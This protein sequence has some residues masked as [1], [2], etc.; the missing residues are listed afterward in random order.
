MKSYLIY[1]I[2]HGMID[3][4]NAGQYI[5]HTDVPL[6]EAGEAQLRQMAEDYEYPQPEIVFS[7]PLR[8]C[9]RT[10]QIL[11]PDAD[12]IP[13]RELIECNF[14]EFEGKTAEELEKHPVFP[15]WLAGEEG[16][17]PPFGE[18]SRDFQQRVMQGFVRIVEGLLK[19]GTTRAA[20]VTHGGVITTLL[21]TFGLPQAPMHEWMMPEGC[22]YTVRVTPFLWTSG[23]KMEVFEELPIVPGKFESEEDIFAD[24]NVEDFLYD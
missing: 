7:S 8:R 1:F 11:Y 19:T 23:Q 9:L 4:G 20:I 10:A 17:E 2:R 3:A 13:M 18:S 15:A 12:V 5:G 16:V 14:G 24:F 21:S 6:S 22:G